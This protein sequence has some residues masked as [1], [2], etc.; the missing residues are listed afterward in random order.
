MADILLELPGG[1]ATELI[2]LLDDTAVFANL[3]PGVDPDEVPP[4]SGLSRLLGNQGTWVPLA[5]WT[6]GEIGLQHPAGQ[7]VVRTLAER[8]VAVPEDWYVVTQTPKRGLV[9]RTYQT[10][11]AV[12]VPWLVQAAAALCPFEIVRPWPA[13]V[14]TR[15]R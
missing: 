12:T 8:G 15:D 14:R 11:P 6:P 13:K 2:A 7:R 3:Q 9:V 1:D 4:R 10:P 5:T